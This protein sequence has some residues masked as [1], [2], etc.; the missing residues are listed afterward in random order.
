MDLIIYI[1]SSDFPSKNIRLSENYHANKMFKT[2]PNEW[3]K[4]QQNTRAKIFFFF[5]S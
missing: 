2:D 5:K 3:D 1:R 4:Q